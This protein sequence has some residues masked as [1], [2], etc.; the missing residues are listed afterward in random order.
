MPI[1]SFI[2][3]C[4][5]D[6]KKYV[7][8]SGNDYVAALSALFPPNKDGKRNKNDTPFTRDEILRQPK[9]T[10]FKF[11]G[12]ND[13]VYVCNLEVDPL[14]ITDEER[15]N[16]KIYAIDFQGEDAKKLYEKRLGVV[17]LLTCLIDDNEYIVKIGCSRTTFKDRLGSYNCG[18]V[19][20][21][22]TASTT[23]IKMLQ[24]FVAT[25]ETFKLY[26]F[27]SGEPEVFNWHGV[28]SLPFASQIIYAVEDI[29]VKKF[30]E[31]FGHKPLVNVQTSATKV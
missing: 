10:D 9:L 8:K 16:E 17:Y 21:W 15:S 20:N 31:I 28:Q 4:D 14:V 6:G 27:D 2:S 13:F 22:R 3:L 30:M 18:T 26:L 1:S 5:F 12:V 7:A 29:L 11:D 19:N 25:R 24:S 23:N